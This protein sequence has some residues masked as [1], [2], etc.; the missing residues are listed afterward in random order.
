MERGGPGP[1]EFRHKQVSCSVTHPGQ[2][3]A[4]ART[5]CLQENPQPLRHE[6]T[7]ERRSPDREHLPRSPSPQIT[8]K[9]HE[10]LVSSPSCREPNALPARSLGAQHVLAGRTMNLKSQ[11][12][13]SP[14]QLGPTERSRMTSTC[15]IYRLQCGGH[16]CPRPPGCAAPKSSSP[17]TLHSQ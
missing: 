9:A 14:G 8:E 6:G 3:R 10:G 17:E 15:S 5:L 13:G 7:A 4:G 1:A 11:R 2:G 16:V 12:V